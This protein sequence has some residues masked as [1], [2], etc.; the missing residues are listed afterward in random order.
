[1]P[2]LYCLDSSSVIHLRNFPQTVLGP[3][4][5][6]LDTL[7]EEKRLLA[8]REVLREVAKME[9][10]GH[11]WAR[12]HRSI[13]VDPDAE[14]GALVGTLQTKY[15]LL[16]VPSKPIHADPWCL[17]LT[18]LKQRA[19]ETCYLINEERSTEQASGKLPWLCNDLGLKWARLLDIPGLEGLRFTLSK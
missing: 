1:V 13:F 15:P 6:L 4:W 5:E 10:A 3:L 19:G 12:D 7:I 16:S 8:P 9:D 17:A 2:N 14:Q 18:L 11:A